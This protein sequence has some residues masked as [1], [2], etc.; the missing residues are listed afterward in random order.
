M[1]S[2]WMGCAL[3]CHSPMQVTV[4]WLCSRLCSRHG[5]RPM[6]G[7]PPGDLRCV[8]T[9]VRARP[10]LLGSP[11]SQASEARAAVPYF[12][13]TPSLE[14]A[15][16]AGAAPLFL[17]S[18]SQTRSSEFMARLGT[19]NK[20]KEGRLMRETI[21]K[22][23]PAPPLCLCLERLQPPA[24]DSRM[25]LGHHSTF[26]MGDMRLGDTPCLTRAPRE[27]LVLAGSRPGAEGFQGG[28]GHRDRNQGSRPHPQGRLG[29]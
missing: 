7:G 10:H 16:V 27:Q 15:V 9:Y 3:V 6:C 26:P 19:I 20:T 8:C 17:V 23:L 13:G 28:A 2:V 5:E 22:M 24:G 12:P 14:K 18:S 4:T 21:S 1:S 25:Q 11:F 29:T